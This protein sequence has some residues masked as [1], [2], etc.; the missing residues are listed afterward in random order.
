VAATEGAVEL[1][2][3]GRRTGTLCGTFWPPSHSA[4]TPAIGIEYF[5]P[6]SSA[7]Q[8]LVLR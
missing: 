8:R 1:V 6:S 3:L 4:T 7:D 5:D 2:A